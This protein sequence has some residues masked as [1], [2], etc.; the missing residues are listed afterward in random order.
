MKPILRVFNVSKSPYPPLALRT[1]IGRMLEF[2]D[3]DVVCTH[4]NTMRAADG[5]AYSRLP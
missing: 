2:R 3:D 1:A 4:V 5:S